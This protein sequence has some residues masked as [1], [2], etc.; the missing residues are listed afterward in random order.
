MKKIENFTMCNI[1]I[2]AYVCAW[3]KPHIHTS[4]FNDLK[5]FY[6]KKN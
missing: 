2:W 3:L 4:D 1:F 6:L 5:N